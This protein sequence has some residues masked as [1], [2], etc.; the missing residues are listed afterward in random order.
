MAADM[1]FPVRSTET[2]CHWVHQFTGMDNGKQ[3]LGKNLFF[4]KERR[5]HLIQIT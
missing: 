3:L 1:G 2:Q 4:K 5:Q